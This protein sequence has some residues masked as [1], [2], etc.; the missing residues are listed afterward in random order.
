MV[1]PDTKDA[2]QSEMIDFVSQF[3]CS[4]NSDETTNEKASTMI[5]LGASGSQVN[6][7]TPS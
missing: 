7:T 1:Y 5:V 4:N 3:R 2:S 6:R